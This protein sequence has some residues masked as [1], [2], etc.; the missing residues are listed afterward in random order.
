MLGITAAPP[1]TSASTYL[2]FFAGAAG[3]WGWM[4]F[5]LAERG[6]HPSTLAAALYLVALLLLTCGFAFSFLRLAKR[7]QWSQ[8]I[9]SSHG[10]QW[11]DRLHGNSDFPTRAFSLPLWAAGLCSSRDSIGSLPS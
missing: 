2:T 5:T 10:W 6:L 1:G 4:I 11:R 8:M 7:S 9:K 3:C